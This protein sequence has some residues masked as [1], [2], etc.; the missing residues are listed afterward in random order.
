MRAGLNV[1]GEEKRRPGSRAGHNELCHARNFGGRSQNHYLSNE[2]ADIA[3][4]S[5]DAIG[6]AAPQEHAIQRQDTRVKS[7][8]EP[9]LY[10]ATQ[11][12]DGAVGPLQFAGD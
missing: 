7:S 3:C 5:L 12:S 8:S 10:S 4:A 6:D 9:R 11:D 1:I 2:L